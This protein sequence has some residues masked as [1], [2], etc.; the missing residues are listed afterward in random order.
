[1]ATMTAINQAITTI[2]ALPG[3]YIDRRFFGDMRRRKNIMLLVQ[4]IGLPLGIFYLFKIPFTV[5]MLLSVWGGLSGGMLSPVSMAFNADVL[6]HG[7]DG[8]PRD[9]TRDTLL[10]GWASYITGIF[11]PV[12][13]GR[14]FNLPGTSR[15]QIYHWM[16]VWQLVLAVATTGIFSSIP[17]KRASPPSSN[18]QA[19]DDGEQQATEKSSA[20]PLG[21]KACD[22]CCWRPLVHR[23][24]HRSAAPKPPGGN[25]SMHG[26]A[27]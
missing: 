24:P 15:R 18:D 25:I 13:G 12:I 23:R 9:P 7:A 3:G 5:V 26:S 17:V 11:I 1:M 27:Q 8:L 10:F 6:P 2:T 22:G 14:L 16:F 4:L 19:V 21:A 20:A